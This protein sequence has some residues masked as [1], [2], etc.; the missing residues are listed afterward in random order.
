MNVVAGAVPGGL[1]LGSPAL[2]QDPRCDV[3]FTQASPDHPRCS[4][5][6]RRVE[7]L[8]CASS[9]QFVDFGEKAGG[10]GK[11]FECACPPPRKIPPPKR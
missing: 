3:S 9:A 10:C 4:I 11:T 2:A 8:P 5:T 7:G 1:A 6:A